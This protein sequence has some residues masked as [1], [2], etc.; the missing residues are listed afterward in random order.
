LQGCGRGKMI[1][2]TNKGAGKGI[3][4][5]EEKKIKYERNR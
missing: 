2:L 1:G 4:E 5:K 3:W